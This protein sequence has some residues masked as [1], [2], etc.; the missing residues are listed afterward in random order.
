MA[1]LRWLYSADSLTLVFHLLPTVS[2][3]NERKMKLRRIVG[4]A[5]A[6]FRALSRDTLAHLT[7]L[8]PSHSSS[9]ADSR[10]LARTAD[11]RSQAALELGVFGSLRLSCPLALLPQFKDDE[12]SLLYGLTK[13]CNRASSDINILHSATVAEPHN[14]C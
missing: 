10:T 5:A 7:P 13:C 11:P 4:I 12:S 1:G 2:Y 6:K 9:P 3:G 8:P 14:A